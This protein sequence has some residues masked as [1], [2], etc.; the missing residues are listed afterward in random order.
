MRNLEV[1]H[2]STATKL[3]LFIFPLTR[4]VVEK[5]KGTVL[6]PAEET[7]KNASHRINGIFLEKLT[8]RY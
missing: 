6:P 4:V 7:V 3:R 2:I 5:D 1:L 8:Q